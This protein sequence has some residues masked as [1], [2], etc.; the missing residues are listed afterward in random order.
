MEA[1]L[2]EKLAA[3]KIEPIFTGQFK[4]LV[5]GLLYALFAQDQMW[6][7]QLVF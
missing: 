3:A 1:N 5:G 6:Q 7:T 4:E 2:Q